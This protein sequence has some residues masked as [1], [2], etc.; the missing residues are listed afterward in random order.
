ME[1]EQ[2][3]VEY[4]KFIDTYKRSEV[5]GEEVGEVIAR[6]AQYFAK[7]NME[8]VANDR[9]RSMIAKDIE[10]RADDNGKPISSTKAQVFLEATPEAQD[11]RVSK[12]HIQN[13]EQFINALK[14]LQKGVLNEYIH[15]TLS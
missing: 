8:L 12:M 10:S 13:I 11:Y 6:L 3:L 14:S 5:S 2:Y 15:Q 4:D 7:F 1:K 9:R